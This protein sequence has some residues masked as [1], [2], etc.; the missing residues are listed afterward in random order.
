MVNE[1]HLVIRSFYI[2]YRNKGC[3]FYLIFDDI[4]LLFSVLKGIHKISYGNLKR[5]QV[6]KLLLETHSSV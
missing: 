6:N 4:V 5:C 3:Y 1:C 2:N